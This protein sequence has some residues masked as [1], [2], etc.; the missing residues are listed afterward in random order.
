MECTKCGRCC[1]AFLPVSDSELNKIKNFVQKNSI[2]PIKNILLK[3]AN[4]VCPYFDGHKCLIYEVRPAICRRYYCFKTAD[5][6]DFKEFSKEQHYPIN[7]WDFV[8]RI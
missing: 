7:M 5:M 4:Q 3:D 2:K 8:E 1:S 6:A